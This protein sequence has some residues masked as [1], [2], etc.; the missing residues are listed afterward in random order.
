[1]QSASSFRRLTTLLAILGLSVLTLFSF[2]EGRK[3]EQHPPVFAQDHASVY[4][5]LSVP[6]ATPAP[7]SLPRPP[8]PPEPDILAHSYL[9]QIIGDP[10][11][12]L[13]R[14]G[15]KQMYPASITK[16]LTSAIAR[17][18]L[19]PTTPVVF[20]SYAKAVGE[21]ESPVPEGEAFMRDDAIRFAL[22]ESANDAAVALAESVGRAQGAFSF[23]DATALF[24]R[25]ANRKAKE[26][27]MLNSHFENPTG[28]DN[29]DHYTTAEDL[30]RLI[31]Y[32]D[33]HHPEMWDFSRLMSADIASLSG[34][35]YHIEATNELLAEFPALK[36]GKTGLT[37]NAK[38]TLILL[39]PVRQN[40]TAVII[41][42]GSDNRFE[43]GRRL[44][45]WLEQ[46]FLQ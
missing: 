9:V 22:I 39:Y 7:D 43:D 42:L 33:E 44:L 31:R 12:L 3:A 27:G 15:A 29:N 19:D 5:V 8:L 34:R 25:E 26:L 45:K 41:L 35:S 46:A 20:S 24:V 23:D 18:K 14:R 11:P 2:Q 16:I 28:L 6:H 38:G 17:E 32:I 30:F 21:K 10:T 1:M 40:R 36:G 4:S 13:E 37:D